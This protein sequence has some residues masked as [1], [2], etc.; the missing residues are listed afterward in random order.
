MDR[1]IVEHLILN[2]SFNDIEKHL[3]VVKKRIRKAHDLAKASGYLDGLPLPPYPESIFDPPDAEYPG[4]VS[5]IDKA[6]LEHSMWI[7]ERR[8]L[9]WHWV[10]VLEELPIKVSSSSFYRFIKRHNLDDKKTSLRVV[11]EIIHA[12]GESLILDWGKLC[13]VIDPETGKKRTLWFLAGVMGHSRYMMV[14]LVWDNKLV[15]TLI[16]LES[17]FNEVGGVCQKITSDNPKC[18]STEASKFEPVLK[19]GFERFCSH[20]GIIAEMLPP[21]DPEKKGKVE[22]QVP[23]VRRLYEAHGDFISL[24]DSQAYI[25]AKVAIA[26]ERKHGTTKQRPLDLFLQNDAPVLKDLPATCFAPEEYHQGVV[27]RDGHI[28]FR[29]KYYSLNENFIGKE[30]FIV[31]SARTVEIYFKGTLVE[32]H[33]RLECVHQSKSTKKHHLILLFFLG[34]PPDHLSMPIMNG[35]EFLKKIETEYHEQFGEIPIIVASANLTSI[36]PISLKHSFGQMKKPLDIDT[37]Y[38]A[39]ECH[40]GHPTKP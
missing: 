9:G 17:M 11:P 21:S 40:C 38:K 24:E 30:V 32:T 18:F 23:Y 5:L 13:D 19:P 8:V 7:K 15:T 37:L 16:T 22:R 39:V 31:G 34:I 10:T 36:D 1:K 20:Y 27:R 4:P 26:N 33:P 2:K 14:R 6:L 28:R 25:T 29:G 12:P 35:T 3:K